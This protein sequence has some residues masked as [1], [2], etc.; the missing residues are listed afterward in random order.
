MN[1]EKEIE[2]HTE[3]VRHH[4]SEIVKYRCMLQKEKEKPRKI[5]TE[6][7]ILFKKKLIENDKQ[8]IISYLKRHNSAKI[9][10]LVQNF[11]V[12]ERDPLSRNYDLDSFRNYLLPHLEEDGRFI[13]SRSGLR[14]TFIIS[15]DP[16]GNSNN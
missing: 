4:R 1:I 8:H 16:D 11:K 9:Q 14:N 15:L 6:E 10:D 7:Q 5:I 13:V 12:A 3:K 2:Y